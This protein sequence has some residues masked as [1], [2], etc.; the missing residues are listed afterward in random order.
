MGACLARGNDAND[1]A[2]NS[3]TVANQQQPQ[4]AA[5]AQQNKALFIIRVIG[6]V[7]QLGALIDEY[8]FGFLKAHTMLIHIWPWLFFRPTRI[9]VGSCG[10]V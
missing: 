2:F 10:V 8:R 1:V 4:R 3:V 5:Q 7:N 6:I 9:E